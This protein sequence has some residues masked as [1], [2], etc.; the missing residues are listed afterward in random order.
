MDQVGFGFGAPPP[1]LPSTITRSAEHGGTGGGP[2]DDLAS[3]GG[4]VGKIKSITV[5]HGTMV[6]NIAVDYG[7]GQ[8]QAHGGGGGS[9][10]TFE[11]ADD[12]W[13]TQIRGRSGSELDQIQFFLSSGRVSPTYGGNGGAPFQETKA[14][15]IIKAFYGRSG[16]LVD[17]IGVYFAD[18]QPLS[19]DITAMNYDLTRLSVLNMPPVEAFVTIL[20]NTTSTAQQLSQQATFQTSDTKQT[21]VAETNQVNVSMTFKTDFLVTG[22]QLQVGYTH[23]ETVTTGTSHTDQKSWTINFNAAVPAMGKVKATAIAKSST[24]D[25][26][27]TATAQVTYQGRPP[28]TMTLHG[29]LQGVATTSVEAE[30]APA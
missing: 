16:S 3:Q 1:A 18:A 9:P 6:D 23:G 19:I 11:L 2:F 27:W 30:Y 15:G 4:A 28:Q 14:N 17:Q 5:R 24:Y 21:S 26:P 22:S 10:D 8:V 29:V 20:D 12:E 7:T 13:L 25:I